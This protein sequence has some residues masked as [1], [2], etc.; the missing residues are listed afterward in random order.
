MLYFIIRKIKFK[1]K[2]KKKCRV[3]EKKVSYYMKSIFQI[4]MRKVCD[5]R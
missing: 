4:P 5:G 2:F 3:F 1:K